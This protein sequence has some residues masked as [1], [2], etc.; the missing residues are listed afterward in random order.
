MFHLVGEST[1]KRAYGTSAHLKRQCGR[2]EN[3]HCD[4]CNVTFE[5]VKDLNRHSMAVHGMTI[6]GEPAPKYFCPVG[7]CEY[8][9]RGSKSHTRKDNLNR[10]I[11]AKHPGVDRVP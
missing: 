2:P 1:E 9:E 3:C 8:S 11:R 5:Y 6:S 7:G 10:H 4:R